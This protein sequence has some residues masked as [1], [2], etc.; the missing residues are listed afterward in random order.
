MLWFGIL[1]GEFILLFISSKFFI[2]L[3]SHVLLR[4][5]HSQSLTIQLL[6]LLFLP[7]VAIHELA[8]ALMASVL[9]VP[10]G[11]IEFLPQ[12]VDGGVKLGSVGI[13]LTDPLRR[14]T[15]A[16]APGW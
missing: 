7:G 14:S 9:F 11:D 10:V 12:L 6:S 1:V 5:T 3:L 16:T 13:G 8:H 2:R 15:A 4:F